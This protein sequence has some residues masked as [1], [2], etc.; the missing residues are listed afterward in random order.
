MLAITSLTLREASRRKVVAAAVAIAIVLIG[1]TG[2]GF[3][4]L[5]A[6]LSG[7]ARDPALVAGTFSVLVVM[8]AYMFS[9]AL[10]IG[11]AFLAAPALSADVDSGLLLAILPRPLRRADVVLGKWLGLALLVIAFVLAVGGAELGVIR[12]IAHYVPPHPLTALAFLA[13][14]SLVMLTLALFF[15][16][17]LAPIA[18]GIIAIALF[19]LAWIAGIAVTLATTLGNAALVHAG[20][21]VSLIVPSDGLWR[22]ALAALEPAVFVASGAT[23]EGAREFGPFAVSGPPPA[24]F[25]I[26]SAAW[27][28][29][30]LAAAVLSFAKRDI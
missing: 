26:W 28:M 30:I 18:G 17:R 16:S 23:A 25:L 15:S 24:A 12:L 9:V 13:A 5:N 21:I 3:W 14:E 22:G 20:T 27:A 7:H 2:W 1:L 19:G 10:A 29:A 4:K 8:L 11:S 6:S